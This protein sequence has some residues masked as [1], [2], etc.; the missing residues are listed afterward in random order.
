M[1]KI[2]TLEIFKEFKMLA[3]LSHSIYDFL[4]PATNHKTFSQFSFTTA[5]NVFFTFNP[6]VFIPQWFSWLMAFFHTTTLRNRNYGT[7]NVQYV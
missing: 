2:R 6:K 3:H 5:H 4:T 7:L 1:H